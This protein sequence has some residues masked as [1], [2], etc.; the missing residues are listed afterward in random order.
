VAGSALHEAH[1]QFAIAAVE[2]S[3]VEVASHSGGGF[4]HGPL[5]DV[6]ES[7]VA[8]ILALGRTA[9]VGV[10]LAK[11][12]LARGGRVILVGSDDRPN[13]ERRLSIRIDPVPEPWE[14]ITS[15]L[16]PH[17]LTLAIA[18]WFGAKLA[19]RFQYGEMKE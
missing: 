14:G 9:A 8:I 10:S 7:H 16:V 19:P 1:G 18:E 3:G 17:A 12:C 15:V 13:S 5:L 11:D 4:R 2:S 6:N